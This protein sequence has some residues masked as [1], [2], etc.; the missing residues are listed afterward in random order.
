M[1]RNQVCVLDESAPHYMT[2]LTFSRDVSLAL[3]SKVHH[4]AL[5]ILERRLPEVLQGT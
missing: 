5:F 4:V 3:N 1:L 2:V